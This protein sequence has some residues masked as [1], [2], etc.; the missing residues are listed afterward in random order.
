MREP[1]EKIAIRMVINVRG[2]EISWCRIEPCCGWTIPMPIATVTHG[3]V[4]LEHV[5]ALHYGRGG[6]G[7][8]VGEIGG[9]I[10][11]HQDDPED[12]IDT[13]DHQT[14]PERCGPPGHP[15]AT[16]GPERHDSQGAQQQAKETGEHG[17]LRSP[18]GCELQTAVAILIE[19]TSGCGKGKCR[20]QSRSAWRL[21]GDFHFPSPCHANKPQRS[22]VACGDG[23]HGTAQRTHVMIAHAEMY[24]ELEIVWALLIVHG[25]ERDIKLDLP[26]VS[27][28][29]HGE[30]EMPVVQDLVPGLGCDLRRPLR[31]RQGGQDRGEEDSP[32][33]Q[34]CLCP[35]Q[36]GAAAEQRVCRARYTCARLAFESRTEP[37]ELPSSHPK[38]QQEDGDFRAENAPI[39][40]IGEGREPIDV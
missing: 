18:Y 9:R 15:A 21:E 36:G 10:G 8:R 39:W 23:D 17:Q 13:A 29:S 6:R 34:G 1:P 20:S 7:N 19:P 33:D 40:G 28:R 2:S 3:T 4:L 14:E 27:P 37:H 5:L 11:I 30:M 25:G 32:N 31:W 26:S 12:E 35:Y 16:T 22:V 24:E 38:C